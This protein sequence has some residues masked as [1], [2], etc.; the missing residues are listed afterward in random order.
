MAK[1]IGAV[2]QELADLDVFFYALPFLL[3]FA[4]VFAVLQKVNLARLIDEMEK[5][6]EIAYT[7]EHINDE[8]M[9][10]IK[11]KALVKEAK[12]ECTRLLKEHLDGFLIN[13]PDAVYED[14]IR[15]LHPDNAYYEDERIDHRFYVEDSDHR[16][17][18]NQKME[19]VDCIE[20]VVDSRHILPVYN[21]RSPRKG[22]S[23][24]SN[25]GHVHTLT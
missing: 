22:N 14:W 5:Q 6:Q 2:L 19:D 7:L 15:H 12:D 25:I 4:L 9:E 10:E 16:R 8:N 23:S 20:R 3:I 17:M 13:N 11:R 21:Q 1:P 24:N 18:W